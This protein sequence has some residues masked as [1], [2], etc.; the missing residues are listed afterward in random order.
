[1]QP[2]TRA[3]IVGKGNSRHK[4]LPTSWADFARLTEIRSGEGIIRFN[5]YNYQISLIE[6]I[7]SHKLTVVG[8]SR[9]LGIS[10]TVCNYFLY[11]ACVDRSVLAVVLSLGQRETID[12]ARRVRFAIESLAPMG[13]TTSTDTLT[14]IQINGGGRLLFRPSNENSTRGL[15]AVT[16][17][18]LD[19]AGFV[20]NVDRIYQ[21]IIPATSTVANPKIVVVSTPNGSQGFYHNLLSNGDTDLVGIC[22]RIRDGSINPYQQW[23]VANTGKVLIHWKCHPKFSQQ[24]DYLDRIA[25]ET[26]LSETVIAQEYDLSFSDQDEAVFSAAIVRAAATLENMSKSFDNDLDYYI[27]VDGATVGNDY[28]VAIVLEHNPA[29]SVY[30]VC[31]LYRKRK[32]SI[33]SDIYQIGVLLDKY[34]PR[35]LT[36]E[37]NGVGQI[38]VEQ[39]TKNHPDIRVKAF[40]TSQ[41]SKLGAIERLV[42]ALEKQVLFMPR[43]SPIVC[44]MLGFRRV[45]KKLQACSGQHDD[46]VMALAICL[47]QTPFTP[48]EN[49]LN[50][51]SSYS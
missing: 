18:L 28:T 14:D 1:M 45:G 49:T 41:E 46:T 38:F 32:A 13:I 21:A 51:T 43:V 8:K 15:P 34:K 23:S 40:H 10:E 9:Q 44:E 17:A 4:P 11:R 12:L 16:H 25:Q 19:E 7:E 31:D 36:I 6:S 20:E 29:T 33:E 37:S 50:L 22:D 47:S 5:P 3:K 2:S 35:R 48:R 39:L 27:G 42:L 30:S 24:E 26:G